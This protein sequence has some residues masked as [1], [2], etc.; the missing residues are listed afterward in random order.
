[1][2][3]KNQIVTITYEDLTFEVD[4]F[5]GHIFFPE[6][7]IRLFPESESHIE[8]QPSCLFFTR[9]VRNWDMKKNYTNQI[10]GTINST[11]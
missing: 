1:M 5:N 2:D 8:I 9:L 4:V 11:E 7:I 3:N 10:D 6:D